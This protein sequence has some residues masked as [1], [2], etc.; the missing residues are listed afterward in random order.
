M[1]DLI[2]AGNS[3]PSPDPTPL[4]ADDVNVVSGNPSPEELAA[5]TAVVH[6]AI[7]LSSVALSP[8]EQSGPN[9]WQRSQ[10]NFRE[11]LHPAPGAWRTFSV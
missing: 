3:N 1:I 2:G 4:E 7:A 8:T 10:R 9:A 6:A 5:V 11:P